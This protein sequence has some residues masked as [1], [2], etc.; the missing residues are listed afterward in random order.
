MLRS[1]SHSKFQPLVSVLVSI[2]IAAG[3]MVGIAIGSIAAAAPAAAAP[4]DPTNYKVT[5]VARY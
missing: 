5:L 1:V 4:T 2:A 3:A